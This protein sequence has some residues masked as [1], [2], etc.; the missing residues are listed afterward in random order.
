MNLCNDTLT[1]FNRRLDP[2][3]G[4]DEYHRTVISGISWYSTVKSTVTDK[5]LKSA[6]LYTIRIP[7]DAV[8]DG[9]SWIDPKGYTE[10]ENVDGLFTL[11]EGDLIVKG[12][13]TL[14]NATPAQI[15]KQFSEAFT[16]LS[17][18]DNRRAPNAKHWKV[19]GA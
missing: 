18:T 4:Y 13:V 6:N 8:F 1:L 16:V 10:A 3:S 15:H 7:I 19:V 12:S 5:G 2:K 11:N 9:K 14:D 17:V